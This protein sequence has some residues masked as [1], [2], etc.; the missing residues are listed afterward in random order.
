MDLVPEKGVNPSEEE[1]AYLQMARKFWLALALSVPVF[2]IAMSDF[3][4]FCIYRIWLQKKSGNGLS[5]YWPH[6]SFFMQAGAFLNGAELCSRRS[7]NMWTLISIGVGAAY[8]FSVLGLL[9]PGLFPSQF[10]DDQGNVACLFRS[11]CCHTYLG[12]AGTGYGIE[13][14]QQD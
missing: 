8:L 4:S 5:F 1:K 12:F 11:G 13:G 7:P 14:T 9:F 6:R 3:F 10:K 2:I